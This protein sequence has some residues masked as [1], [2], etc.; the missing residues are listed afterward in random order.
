M[1]IRIDLDKCTGCG[2]C[3]SA[4]PFGIIELVDDKA[5]IGDGCTLCGACRDAC[6]FEA[7]EIDEAEE[8]VP[9]SDEYQGIWIF[10]EQR[11]GI[12]RSVA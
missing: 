2:S 12:L 5:V 9:V 7:I 8:A 11:D 6:D 1:G 10:A 4:C 3:V